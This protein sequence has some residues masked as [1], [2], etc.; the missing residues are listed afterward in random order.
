MFKVHKTPPFLCA[1]FEAGVQKSLQTP[2]KVSIVNVIIC[3]S[4]VDFREYTIDLDDVSNFTVFIKTVVNFADFDITVL[5]FSLRWSVTDEVWGLS[6]GEMF[7]TIRTLT[8]DTVKWLIPIYFVPLFVSDTFSMNWHYRTRSEMNFYAVF[9]FWIS[10]SDHQS[11][12]FRVV[13]L[14]FVKNGSV[15][16][17]MLLRNAFQNTVFVCYNPLLINNHR[18]LITGKTSKWITV[19]DVNLTVHSSAE[20]YMK[21]DATY[22]TLTKFHGLR[23]VVTITGMGGR[24]DIVNLFVAIGKA[25]TNHWS[26]IILVYRFWYWIYG[27]CQFRLW[28]Y[29]LHLS[30]VTWKIQW[31]PMLDLRSGRK[32]NKRGGESCTLL[33]LVMKSAL[34]MIW[35]I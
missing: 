26:F 8:V 4:L 5:V 20:R 16:L 1:K 31:K 34:I 18:A 12:I 19:N 3:Q 24:F 32:Q 30:L 6:L 17:I 27:Y 2:S 7:V 33:P 22:R 28:I 15:T 9:V 21:D 25:E 23:F 13:W 14:K 11:G 10:R 29:L 35:F